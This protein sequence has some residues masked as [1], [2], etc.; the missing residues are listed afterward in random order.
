MKRNKKNCECDERLAKRLNAAFAVDWQYDAVMEIDEA[1]TLLHIDPEHAA[2]LVSVG[3]LESENDGGTEIA[4]AEVVRFIDAHPWWLAARAKNH[5]QHLRQELERV[6][7]AVSR[8]IGF[9]SEVS[10]ELNKRMDREQRER[11]ERAAVH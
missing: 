6:H 7:R 9:A 10:R 8:S 3:L 4:L 2:Q 1:A 5:A 11:A